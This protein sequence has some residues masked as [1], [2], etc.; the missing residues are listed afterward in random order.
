MQDAQ[1]GESK[2]ELLPTGLD[3]T[4]IISCERREA[5]MGEAELEKLVVFHAPTDGTYT[6][7]A[8]PDYYTNAKRTCTRKVRGPLRKMGWYC[9][10]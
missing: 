6:P 3:E 4:I 5:P 9:Y 1:D 2:P 10:S 7:R 8:F